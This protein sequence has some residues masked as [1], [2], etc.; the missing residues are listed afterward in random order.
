MYVVITSKNL[1]YE[2]LVKSRFYFSGC[3]AIQFLLKLDLQV[4]F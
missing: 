1:G 3:Y 4:V 2:I